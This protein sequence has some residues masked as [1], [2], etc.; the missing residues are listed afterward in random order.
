[1]VH[2]ID[3]DLLT[4]AIY[5]MA[6]VEQGTLNPHVVFLLSL[7]SVTLLPASFC[8]PHILLLEVCT[9]VCSVYISLSV[10]QETDLAFAPPI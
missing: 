4:R 2:Y 6:C 8:F 10:Y 3:D 1:M 5:L 7:N 9:F